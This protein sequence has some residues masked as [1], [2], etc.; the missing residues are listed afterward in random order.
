[1]LDRGI[2]HSDAWP[3]SEQYKASFGGVP[4]RYPQPI[5]LIS[6]PALTATY[7]FSRRWKGGQQLIAKAR[8]L[9]RGIY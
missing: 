8:N 3:G 7:D 6:S 4:F 9:S 1:M 5:E 2:R